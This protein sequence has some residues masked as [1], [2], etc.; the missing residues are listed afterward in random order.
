MLGWDD[1]DMAMEEPLLPIKIC[2]YT[3]LPRAALTADGL[4][5][6]LGGHEVA[7]EKVDGEGNHGEERG[8]DNNGVD[9]DMVVL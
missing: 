1:G 4:L 9:G 2:N 8:E 6:Q 5:R 3:K 7:I